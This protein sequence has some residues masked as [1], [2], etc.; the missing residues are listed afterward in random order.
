MT[1]RYLENLY[2]SDP[3]HPVRQA[4]SIR[5]NFKI[6]IEKLNADPFTPTGKLGKSVQV[7]VT[8]FA[9]GG[10]ADAIEITKDVVEISVCATGGDSVKLPSA[11]AGLFILIINHG[12]AAADVFPNTD[13]AI[14]E[15]AVN[16]AKSLDINASML[17]TAYDN[18]NWECL[19]LA[20]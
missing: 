5:H 13:D 14:N 12:V 18:T 3:D 6:I 9:G 19:T 15:E 1:E 7:E 2:K 16:T 11:V 10:Q 4:L 20:R 17:C 8:A